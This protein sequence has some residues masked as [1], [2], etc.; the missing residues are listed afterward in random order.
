MIGQMQHWWRHCGWQGQTRVR[1]VLRE[2]KRA[3]A[4]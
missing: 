4:A 1:H 3:E 2:I